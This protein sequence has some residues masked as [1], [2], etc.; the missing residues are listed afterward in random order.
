MPSSSPALMRFFVMVMSSSLGFES[1][2]V[3][4]GAPY[5]AHA[6]RSLPSLSPNRT[7]AFQRIRLSIRHLF[8]R[9]VIPCAAG[10]HSRPIVSRSFGRWDFMAFLWCTCKLLVPPHLRHLNPSLSLTR[11]F[12]STIS[13]GSVRD[14]TTL[15]RYI[16]SDGPTSPLGKSLRSGFCSNR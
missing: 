15:R 12:R 8:S 4:K 7:C 3:E 11:S 5:R 14:L 10:G 2:G 1:R 6:L 13:L 16:C 9:H